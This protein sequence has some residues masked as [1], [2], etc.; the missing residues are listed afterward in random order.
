MLL[1]PQIIAMG[2]LILISSMVGLTIV[3]GMTVLLVIAVAFLEIIGNG[4]PFPEFAILSYLL[5]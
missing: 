1:D 2:A 4:I 3:L 5:I